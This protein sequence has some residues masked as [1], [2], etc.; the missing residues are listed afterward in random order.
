[1]LQVLRVLVTVARRL[2]NVKERVVT[3]VVIESA[4]RPERECIFR[5]LLV[6]LALV[7]RMTTAIHVA[8]KDLPQHA[9][10]QTGT[11]FRFGD[12]GFGGGWPPRRRRWCGCGCEG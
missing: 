12:G 4:R 1:M 3:A 11:G 9:G 10:H 2:Q 7:I 6:V 5:V 8:F